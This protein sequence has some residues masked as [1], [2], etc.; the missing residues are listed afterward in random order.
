[1][2]INIAKNLVDRIFI[3]FHLLL[4]TICVSKWYQYLRIWLS[5]NI[6]F[7]SVNM[8]MPAISNELLVH[9][10]ITMISLCNL[11]EISAALLPRCLWNSRAKPASH[12]FETS[13]DLAVRR[14]PG[15][16]LTVTRDLCLCM[17]IIYIFVWITNTVQYFV[18]T[19]R[20]RCSI[21]VYSNL[22]VT[23]DSYSIVLYRTVK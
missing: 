6:C 19:Y 3:F 18:V 11:T 5:R 9:N 15:P 1:M 20:K 14:T 4:P 16:D 23:T 10:L 13:R 21:T 7:V 8:S 17:F 12:S 2:Q 22:V